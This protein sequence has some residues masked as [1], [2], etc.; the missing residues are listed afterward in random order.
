[1]AQ[2]TPFKTILDVLLDSKKD[3]PPRTLQ[4]FSDIDPQSLQDLLEV[5]RRVQPARKLLLLDGLSSLLD[6]D[7]LVC[8]DDIGRA[9]LDDPD[10][11]VRSRAIRLLAECNDPKLVPAFINILKNDADPAPRIEAATVLGEFVLLGELEELSESLRHQAEEALLATANSEDQP[12]LRRRAIESLG[13]S[14]RPEVEILI[15]SAFNRQNPE[16]VASALRAMGRSSDERWGDQV[17]SMLL[18]DE[19][20]IR[21]A[22]VQAAGELSLEPARAILLK[23]LVEEEE[24]DDDVISAAIWSLSQIGGEEVRIYI[25]SLIDRAEDD[26]LVQY[27]E[28][29]LSNLDFTEELE[30]FDMLSIEADDEG[31]EA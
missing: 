3:L 13:F 16:W 1:M 20:H 24:G 6:S 22:A 12:A 30:H 10:P 8:F 9:L 18:N 11:G 28:E 23:M 17:V 31:E 15:E 4:H 7:T 14:S 25:E 27:L 26:G 29:A 2:R 21:L 19:D 5:W